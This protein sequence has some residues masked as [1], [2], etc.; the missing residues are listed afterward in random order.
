MKSMLILT[1]FSDAAFRAAEYGCQLADSLGI[2]RIVLY[3]A[4]QTMVTGTDLPVTTS[5]NNHDIYLENMEALGLLHDQLKSMSGHAV[6]IDLLADNTPLHSIINQRCREEEID[7]IVMGVSGK[8]D[9]EKLLIGSTTTQILETSEVPVLVVPKGTFIGKGIKTIVFTTDLKDPATVPVEQLYKFL[10]AFPADLCVVN[11][12][13]A[14]EEKYLSET[15]EAIAS[16]HNLLEKYQPTFH[17]INEDDT[18]KGILAFS[19][20]QHA[21]LIMAVPKRHST[22][23]SLFRRS[24]SK[25]LAYDSSIP[26]LSLPATK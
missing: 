2:K 16:L 10:D 8:S 11:V 14:G 25:K 21:S 9:L 23:A 6:A 26:L 20:Q 4:Y 15:K 22:F 1:D 17:Y 5:K 18:V 12:A 13:P 7:I 24:I 3:H 19:E